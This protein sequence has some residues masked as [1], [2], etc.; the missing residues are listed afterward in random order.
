M[1][2]TKRQ[3]RRTIRK[4]LL[5]S[6]SSMTVGQ[7][8][9]QYPQLWEVLCDTGDYDIDGYGNGSE[10]MSQPLTEFIEEQGLS[11]RSA[12]WWR[13]FYESEWLQAHIALEVIAGDVGWTNL[14]Y[15][16]LDFDACYQLTVRACAQFDVPV[17][18]DLEATAE[19]M[20]DHQAM[21][22]SLGSNWT[23]DWRDKFDL[24]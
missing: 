7:M 3:L 13:E 1:K 4:V 12:G 2:I 16:G 8:S 22:A 9:S 11:T 15:S 20:D 17:P 6:I 5:E 24:N 23:E 19:H 21:D 18:H 14:S 10:G